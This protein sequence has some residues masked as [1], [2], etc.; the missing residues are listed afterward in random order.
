MI[1]PMIY[2]VTRWALGSPLGISEEFLREGQ[3]SGNPSSNAEQEVPAVAQTPN[4][5]QGDVEAARQRLLGQ[6]R[7]VRRE[8]HV[9]ERHE[10]VVG[11]RGILG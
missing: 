7:D 11:R 1:V 5:L 9:V 4:V 10:R 8:H 2:A 3:E 6:P